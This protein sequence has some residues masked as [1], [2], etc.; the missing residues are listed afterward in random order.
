MKYREQ[1]LDQD[2]RLR[3]NAWGFHAVGIFLELENPTNKIEYFV[4]GTI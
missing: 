4:A 1:K 2:L 3:T